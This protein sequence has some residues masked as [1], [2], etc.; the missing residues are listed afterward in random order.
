MLYPENH[1]VV[2][3]SL[4]RLKLYACLFPGASEQLKRNFNVFIMTRF[5]T[6]KYILLSDDTSC[7]NT[8]STRAI[9]TAL[10]WIQLGTVISMRC[11]FS[12]LF[13]HLILLFYCRNLLSG[14]RTVSP[15]EKVFP[16]LTYFSIVTSQAPLFALV[17]PPFCIFSNF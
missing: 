16:P 8:E 7:W 13:H 14:Q 12:N 1:Y 10:D 15:S 2:F 4:V 3:I 6:H 5:V 11:H 9:C 17:L